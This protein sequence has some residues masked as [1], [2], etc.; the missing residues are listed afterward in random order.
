MNKPRF[1]LDFNLGTWL[2]IILAIIG[3]F[4]AY[5]DLQEQVSNLDQRGRMRMESSD[6]F[7]TE[8]KL[9]LD[10]VADIPIRVKALET[11]Q[12]AIS[13]R[14]DRI[15]DAITTGQ[16]ALRRDLAASTDTLRKDVA[17]LGTKVEVLSD[18][19]GV[20]PQPGVLIRPR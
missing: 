18:R 13:D 15:S 17:I 19:M 11:Q 7:Q 9:K 1:T 10:S 16:E 4:S 6:K 2:P 3:G 14:L 20:R 12:Q 8:T 5:R